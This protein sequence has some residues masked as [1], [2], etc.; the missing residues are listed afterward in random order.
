MD[1]FGACRNVEVLLNSKTFTS[2]LAW[3]FSYLLQDKHIVLVV[4]DEIFCFAHTLA[5]S[6]LADGLLPV[7]L[8]SFLDSHLLL[9]NQVTGFILSYEIGLSF[10]LTA[11]MIK[12][13]EK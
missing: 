1:L 5:F 9:A 8:S 6:L 7:R 11:S 3:N 2:S 12:K 4:L 13:C 10:S